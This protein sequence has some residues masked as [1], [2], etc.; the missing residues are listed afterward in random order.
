[1]NGKTLYILPE[2]TFKK[3]ELPVLARNKLD[4]GISKN[5]WY[6]QVVPHESLFAFAVLGT[7]ENLAIFKKAVDGKVVQFGGQCFH[8]I[9]SLQGFGEGGIT[10]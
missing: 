9:R 5:L 3:I 6:E 2:E 10:I 1:M 7:E 8:W 4:N